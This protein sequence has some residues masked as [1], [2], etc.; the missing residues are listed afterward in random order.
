MQRQYN[1]HEFFFGHD[2]QEKEASINYVD[3][4][5]RMKMGFGLNV[6]ITHFQLTF[7]S[8]DWLNQFRIAHSPL[9]VNVVYGCPLVGG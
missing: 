1:D 8:A 4:I 6:E 5:L 3:R 2:Q 7:K 9:I